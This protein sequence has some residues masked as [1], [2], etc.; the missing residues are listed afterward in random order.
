MFELLCE[1]LTKE[2]YGRTVL[3][4]PVKRILKRYRIVAGIPILRGEIGCQ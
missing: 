3:A 1:C 2:G 4:D